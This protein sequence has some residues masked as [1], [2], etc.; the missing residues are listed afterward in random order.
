MR[1][2]V[3][4]EHLIVGNTSSQ[5]KWERAEEASRNRYAHAAIAQTNVSSGSQLCIGIAA[6]APILLTAAFG[7]ANTHLVLSLMPKLL[8]AGRSIMDVGSL[9]ASSA[10]AVAAYRQLD[11]YGAA[12]QVTVLTDRVSW[13]KISQNARDVVRQGAQGELSGR[14]TIRGPNGCGKTAVLLALKLAQGDRAVFVPAV[15]V[16]A[17]SERSTGQGIL[18]FVREVIAERPA[19]LLLDEWDAHLDRNAA[20][21]LEG[22]IRGFVAAGGTVVE[23]LHERD[24]ELPAAA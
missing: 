23:A 17:A 9:L 2:S 21:A 8:E 24:G 1:L 16:G 7:V 10:S 5:T 6:Y 4:F 11:R 12:P 15:G 19:I 20:E 3:G 14:I 18:Q 22:E 13:D